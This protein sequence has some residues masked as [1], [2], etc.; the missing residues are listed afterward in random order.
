[1][2]KSLLSLFL[3]TESKEHSMVSRKSVLFYATALGLALAMT[4]CGKGFKLNE[5]TKKPVATPQVSIPVAVTN[6][7]VSP[8]VELAAAQSPEFAAFVNDPANRGK[9]TIQ[10]SIGFIISQ[11]NPGENSG[12][13]SVLYLTLTATTT[14]GKTAAAMVTST[15]AEI[16][17]SNVMNESYDIEG[18]WTLTRGEGKAPFYV[19]IQATGAY[20]SQ[21]SMQL[22]GSL[23][24]S[25]NQDGPQTIAT[26]QDDICKLVSDTTFIRQIYSESPEIRCATPQ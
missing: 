2:A 7:S 6:Q 25:F 17:V 8:L 12:H 3:K 21:Y 1:M 13:D 23:I 14:D 9:I 24:A 15:Q 5:D 16:A 26:F 19:G 18:Y 4:A 22:I 11:L 20:S 10:S